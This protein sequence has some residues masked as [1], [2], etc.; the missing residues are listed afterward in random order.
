MTDFIVALYIVSY[1]A[2]QI[3]SRQHDAEETVRV[4][5]V[6]TLLGIAKKNFDSMTDFIVALYIVS[7][8]TE[9]VKSRQHDAEETVRVEVVNTLL[10]IAKKNV[11]YS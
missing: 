5:V 11:R 2:E 6:N 4:E 1:I 8:I 9:Q 7:C 10:G 3:K